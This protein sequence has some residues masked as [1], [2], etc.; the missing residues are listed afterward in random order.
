MDMR[1]DIAKTKID[2]AMTKID[3]D[4]NINIPKEILKVLNIEGEQDI[5]IEVKN[6]GLNI[7]KV[8]LV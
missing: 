3:K 6:N 7:Q 2:F 8:T 5:I 1:D 4:G